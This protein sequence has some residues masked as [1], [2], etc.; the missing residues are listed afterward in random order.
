M[1]IT[2][3]SSTPAGKAAGTAVAD[4]T[5]TVSN[6]F[7][8]SANS[9]L[10]IFWCNQGN[11]SG[12][13]SSLAGGGLTYS[14]VA[15]ATSLNKSAVSCWVADVGASPASMAITATHSAADQRTLEIFVLVLNGAKS[16]ATQVA[17]SHTAAGN[18]INLN[19]GVTLAA[20]AADSWI[21]AGA[22][23][24]EAADTPTFP[25]GQGDSFNVSQLVAVT[26]TGDS[27]WVQGNTA[28]GNSNLKMNTTT[29]NLASINN[30]M[31]G[32]EVLAAVVA[33][34][35][36]QRGLAYRRRAVPRRGAGREVLV[37][38]ETGLWIPRMI[39]RST[40]PVVV[41]RGRSTQPI[42]PAQAAP[43]NP[44]FVTVR[45]GQRGRRYLWQRRGKTQE[46]IWPAQAAPVNPNFVPP[47]PHIQRRLLAKARGR[48]RIILPMQ[49]PFSPPNQPHI[50]RRLVA[51]ARGKTQQSIWSLQTLPV[52]PNFIPPQPRIPRRLLASTRG[53]ARVIVP[54]QEQAPIFDQRRRP[55]A[56]PPRGRTMLPLHHQPAPV[57]ALPHPRRPRP[58]QRRGRSAQ[59][60]WTVQAP[61]PTP[62]NPPCI[63]LPVTAT[64]DDSRTSVTFD[65]LA[66]TAAFD[67]MS[68]GAVLDQLKGAASFDPL[69]DI[70]TINPLA[71]RAALDPLVSSASLAAACWPII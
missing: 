26:A 11:N 8:P 28:P 6:T 14:K 30:T 36:V 56:R 10:L 69:H 33:T 64:L 53:R 37:T 44:N 58:W 21:F 43:V 34:S 17:S 4:V 59:P 52:N 45:P 71:D 27:G 65:P 42:W 67:P 18:G 32:V 47:P 22:S 2:V 70:A 15:D 55:F 38:A 54:I 66:G 1:A 57:V 13:P 29:P 49:E 24:W 20:A 5:T 41:R 48:A 61:P 23:D 40:R 35:W 16:A 68:A 19:T 12:V 63:A 31:L 62:H 9:L 25:A 51:K 60:I 46:P 39:D 7:T 50:P 3:D